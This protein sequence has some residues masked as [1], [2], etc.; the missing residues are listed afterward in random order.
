M[1]TGTA[2]EAAVL[3]V[4]APGGLL[5]TTQI[6]KQAQLSTWSAR[7]VI[8]QLE[9]RGLIMAVPFQARWAITSHGTETAK[10]AR[11]RVQ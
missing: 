10:V 2:A 8:E 7:R 5:T 4:L 3:D 9:S 11:G 6:A 1:G